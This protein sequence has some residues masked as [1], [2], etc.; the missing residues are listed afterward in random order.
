MVLTDESTPLAQRTS[1]LLNPSKAFK[2]L[3]SLQ[4]P[5]KA[6]HWWTNLLSSGVKLPPVVSVAAS[7][8]YKASSSLQ[9]PTKSL[10]K[11]QKASKP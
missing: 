11:P 6:S 4:R 7:L 2:A 1:S 8:G 3:E 5:P 9:K 10:Q